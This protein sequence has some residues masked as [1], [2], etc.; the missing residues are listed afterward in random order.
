MDRRYWSGA[1]GRGERPAQFSAWPE[2]P[3]AAPKASAKSTFV[4]PRPK[5]RAEEAHEDNSA[6]SKDLSYEVPMLNIERAAAPIRC[7]RAFSGAL[8]R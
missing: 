6:R 4:P 5:K 2:L 7:T 3:R 1:T 8:R